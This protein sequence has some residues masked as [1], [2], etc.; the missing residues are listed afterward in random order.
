V[1]TDR[2]GYAP[3]LPA[4]E[5]GRPPRAGINIHEFPPWGH[6]RTLQGVPWPSDPALAGQLLAVPASF[7]SNSQAALSSG[8]KK[9]Q[10]SL[11]QGHRLCR[12]LRRARLRL[13]LEAGVTATSPGCPGWGPATPISAP[14]Q[15]KKLR[16]GPVTVK[17]KAIPDP[18]RCRDETKGCGLWGVSLG[19]SGAL[20]S[21]SFLREG[22]GSMPGGP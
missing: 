7:G 8:L 14:A 4:A 5:A 15:G 11:D 21:E 17:V 6:P 22:V 16:H 2:Q 3:R 10:V 18:E 20:D 19:A 13:G 9:F 1:V 12:A